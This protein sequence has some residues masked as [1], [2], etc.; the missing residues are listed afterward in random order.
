MREVVWGCRIHSNSFATRQIALRLRAADRYDESAR[1]RYGGGLRGMSHQGPPGPPQYGHPPHGYQPQGYPPQGYQGGP[2]Q[3]P[4]PP[5]KSTTSKILLSI[6]LGIAGLCVVSMIASKGSPTQPGGNAGVA[7]AASAAPTQAQH[8]VGETWQLGDFSYQVTGVEARTRIGNRYMGRTAAPGTVFV[9]VNYVETN[10]SSETATGL[11]DTC[12]VQDSQNRTFHPSSEV[13]T[14]LMM[15][16]GN[17]DLGISQLQPGVPHSTTAGFEMPA[18]AIS[19]AAINLVFHERGLLGS[20]QVVVPVT[21][22]PP[23]S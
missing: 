13:Q 16:G 1:S 15:A 7:A 21:V 4:P 6:I 2:W 19:G 9:L 23:T 12:Q 18:N 20:R 5:R 17:H 10:N 14:A 3:G 8:A 11:S 22:Q